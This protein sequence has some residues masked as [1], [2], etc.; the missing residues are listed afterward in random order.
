MAAVAALQHHAS[1]YKCDE[2]VTK[3]LSSVKILTA[4]EHLF[5]L[6]AESISQKIE[7]LLSVS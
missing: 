5:N 1:N 3:V 6:T 2:F 4:K 7:G